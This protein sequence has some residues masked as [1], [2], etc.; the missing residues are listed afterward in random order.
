M[1]AGRGTH[2][3]IWSKTNFDKVLEIETGQEDD[4]ELGIF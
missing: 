4:D 3:Q 1:L 2:F